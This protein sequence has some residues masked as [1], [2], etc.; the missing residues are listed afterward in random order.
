M[1]NMKRKIKGSKAMGG[2]E[3]QNK[4]FMLDLGEQRQLLGRYEEWCCGQRAG[5]VAKGAK[6]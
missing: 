3:D 4:M 2:T 5:A 6:L 1:G